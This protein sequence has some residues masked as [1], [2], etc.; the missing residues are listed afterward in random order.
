MGWTHRNGG[1]PFEKGET[2]DHSRPAKT[3]RANK[4]TL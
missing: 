4:R 2:L 3:Q 1:I